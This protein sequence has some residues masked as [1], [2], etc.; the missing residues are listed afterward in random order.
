MP[1][2]HDYPQWLNLTDVSAASATYATSETKL[3]PP[4]QQHVLEIL[5]VETKVSNQPLFAGGPGAVGADVD[6]ITQV[7]ITKTLQSAIVSLNHPDLVHKREKE[8][9]SIAF[10]AT[11]TGGGLAHNEAVQFRKYAIA[12]K[13]FLVAA[14]SFHFAVDIK[15]GLTSIEV[16]EARILARYV[17]VDLTQLIEMVLQ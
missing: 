14:T 2:A 9:K 10:E 1:H 6:A 16:Q 7:Q 4:S 15:G 5:G 8:E 12:D 11:E 3:N 13:G 17:K